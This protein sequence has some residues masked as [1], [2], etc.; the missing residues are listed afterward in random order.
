MK[1][2][3]EAVHFVM[4]K[5]GKVSIKPTTPSKEK[6][7]SKKGH[8]GNLFEA[9]IARQKGS[10]APSIVIRKISDGH[11]QDYVDATQK[12]V[13]T[14]PPTPF[15]RT[16]SDS[17]EASHLPLPEPTE[18]LE[19]G[20][21]TN[22]ER[23]I[24]EG[25]VDPSLRSLY[26]G[27]SLFPQNTLGT[28][29]TST[30]CWIVPVYGYEV[31]VWYFLATVNGYLL[32]NKDVSWILGYVEELC[33]IRRKRISFFDDVKNDNII[34]PTPTGRKTKGFQFKKTKETYLKSPSNLSRT[35]K[36]IIQAIGFLCGEESIA[37]T[38]GC[39]ALF[40]WAR[41]YWYDVFCYH[42]ESPYR[43]PYLESNTVTIH[44]LDPR[45]LW[46][47]SLFSAESIAKERLQWALTKTLVRVPEVN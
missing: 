16:A 11:T 3:I 32:N 41:E 8:D 34:V 21:V 9:T 5:P 7:S 13:A 26:L 43:K 23:S 18:A 33:K 37:S 47:P 25:L 20:L 22:L 28:I 15:L 14:L 35:E 17:E 42:R 36:T 45:G 6:T 19:K 46:N 39:E 24:K 1:G 4:K 10:Q 27:L 29:L 2:R 44:F 31:V 12:F 38:L 30:V 40:S